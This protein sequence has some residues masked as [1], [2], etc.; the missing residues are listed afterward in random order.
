MENNIKSTEVAVLLVSDND[1]DIQ[2]VKKHLEITTGAFCHIW[3]CPSIIRSAGFFKKELPGIDMLL[4]DLDLVASERPREIFHQMQKI[5]GAVP[6]IVFTERKN[7]EPVLMVVEAG[8]VDK[9]TR[10]QFSTDSYKLRNAIKFPFAHLRTSRKIAQNHKANVIHIK[11]LGATDIKSLQERQK[12]ALVE[13]MTEASIVLKEAVE[14]SK[15]AG[16]WADV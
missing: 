12:N 1:S 11:N 13:A 16:R 9:V 3:Q 14:D 8:V 2:K 6:I 15:A 5:V 7:H 10:G 4:L